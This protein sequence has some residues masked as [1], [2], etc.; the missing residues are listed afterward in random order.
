VSETWLKES[1]P[2]T[3]LYLPGY[4]IPFRADRSDNSGYGGLLIWVKDNISVSHKSELDH[5]DL[6]CVWLEV[7]IKDFNLLLAVIYRPPSSTNAFWDI[8]HEQIGLSVSY[9]YK[10][11]MFIG[12]LNADLNTPAG[13]K[14]MNLASLNCLD[15]I[16]REPTRI[17]L[18]TSSIL[19]QCLTNQTNKITEV[20]NDP[21]CSTNDHNTIG[22]KLSLNIPYPKAYKRFMWDFKH[23]NFDLFRDNLSKDDFS[24]CENI[25]D[26]N[27]A[28]LKW[29][30]LILKAAH[31]SIPGKIVLIRT[32][33]K[34]WFRSYLRCLKRKK[35]RAHV[36][37]KQYNTI[38]SWTIFKSKRNKYLNE[39]QKCK[40]NYENEQ[41]RTLSNES[42]KN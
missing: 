4:Q 33:D 23:A 37:A 28:V 12:D 6:E 35:D 2:S 14:L 26:I 17:T 16:I 24:F 36:K 38:E 3:S 10:N 21:P 20:I 34:P 31:D 30:E 18:N 29:T 32:R 5:K 7:A 8:L 11:L 13:K 19:D 39:I 42:C 15:I 41:L 25:T 40:S 9:G 1:I 27:T 22:V